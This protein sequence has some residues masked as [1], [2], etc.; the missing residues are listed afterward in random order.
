MLAPS[1]NGGLNSNVNV[2]GKSEIV[3]GDSHLKYEQKKCEVGHYCVNGLRNACPP[4]RYAEREGSDNEF[5]EG[6]CANGYFCPAG[7]YSR[8]QYECGSQ[9]GLHATGVTDPTALYCPTGMNTGSSVPTVVTA[10]FYTVGGERITNKTR[11]AQRICPVGHYC[12]DGRRTRCPAGRYGGTEGLYN[13]SC[14]DKCA[15][16]Y[17]CPQGSWNK[18]QVE[19]GRGTR[20]P[21]Y[22]L[23]TGAV[24]TYRPSGER[25]CEYHQGNILLDITVV[26]H[27]VIIIGNKLTQ[28]KD[29]VTKVYGPHNVTKIVAGDLV[30][31]K[32]DTYKGSDGEY[33]VKAV[34]A[35]DIEFDKTYGLPRNIVGHQTCTLVTY[36]KAKASEG[37][38]YR[39]NH[40]VQEFHD[41]GPW[42]VHHQETE[43]WQN[44]EPRQY[45]YH[46]RVRHPSRHRVPGEPSSVYCPRGSGI[47]TQ[48]EMGWYTTGG[49]ATTNMTRGGERKCEPGY[50]C[51]GGKKMQCPPGR[52]GKR[53][54]ETSER[55]SGYCP[56]GFY[57][58]WNTSAPI[59]CP[60]GKYSAHGYFQCMQCIQKS[61]RQVQS[62][63]C[64]DNRKC[65]NT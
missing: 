13:I 10:G 46:T 61:N 8:K 47:P 15:Q 37:E 25:R 17:F 16:G 40:L 21:C 4:G 29:T 44:V 2:D 39:W 43:H 35:N 28:L 36:N 41:D 23:P 18:D 65:C 26:L 5:C 14:T 62:Q 42:S 30:Q 45:H 12:V 24:A 32:C 22:T 64:R 58:P 60:V 53:Y 31:M 59:E 7:S 27:N 34:N 54:G 63:T 33:M 50:F 56:A 20:S 52:Y 9:R 57:C 19:C 3:Q 6:P 11:F 49:N 48:V 55:C 1:E 38:F 51:E